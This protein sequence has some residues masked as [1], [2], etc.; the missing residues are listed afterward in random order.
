M[1]LPPYKK[2]G[3]SK[4]VPYAH[5]SRTHSENQIEQVADS[6]RE[7]GFLNPVIFDSENGM[8]LAGHCRIL[9][10]EKV[11]MKEIPCIDAKHLSEAQKK[12]YIIAD[13]KLALNAGWDDDIL[14]SE[15]MA[16]D[17]MNYDIGLT[18]FGDDEIKALFGEEIETEG[19]TDVDDTPEPPETPKS[20]IGDIWIL[21][22]HRGNPIC[23][24]RLPSMSAQARILM[25]LEP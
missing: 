3:I 13:N 15:F 19:L 6:I 4:L 7:F 21:G 20:G 22:N 10:A 24:A 18:G 8:I 14:R 12:A 16:L 1:N 9:A 2:E 17:E 25:K 5:N 23:S 11:G